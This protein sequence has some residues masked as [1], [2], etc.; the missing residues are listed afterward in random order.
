MAIADDKKN[1]GLAGEKVF[2]V[3]GIA[4]LRY[5]AHQEA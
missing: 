5:V 1:P 3:H 2:V 4:A